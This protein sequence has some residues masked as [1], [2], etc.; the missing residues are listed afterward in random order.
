M[1][2][3]QLTS[4]ED[5]TTGE[6]QNFSEEDNSEDEWGK[7]VYENITQKKCDS[8]TDDK[9]ETTDDLETVHRWNSEYDDNFSV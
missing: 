7:Y 8:D 4:K 1:R 6:D 3:T 9:M 5:G 2:R